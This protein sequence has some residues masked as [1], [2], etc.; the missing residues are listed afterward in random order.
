MLRLLVRVRDSQTIKKLKALAKITYISQLTNTV[1]IE[2]ASE[3][4]AAKI[5]RIQGV[6]TVDEDTEVS[7]LK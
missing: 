3:A 6:L 4:A 5:A 2:A 1:G 7:I